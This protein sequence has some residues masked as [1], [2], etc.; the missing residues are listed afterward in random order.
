MPDAYRQSRLPF[1]LLKPAA[2][3]A[4]L[5]ALLLAAP[6][7][8]AE[9]APAP[10]PAP[11]IPPNVNGPRP[12]IA[13]PLIKKP[14]GISRT[15]RTPGG[16]PIRDIVR[17]NQPGVID[18]NEIGKRSFDPDKVEAT[19]AAEDE[20][21]TNLEDVI[22]WKSN[23]EQ[24][25]KCKKLPLNA[26]IRLDFNEISLGD[27]TKFI[28]CVTEQNFIITGGAN[29]N[30]T[31]SILSP[32]PVTA[33]EA[34]KAYLSALQANG[35]SITQNG[36]FLEI[37]PAGET[38]DETR[39]YGVGK[40]GPNT[41]QMV[42]RLI[43]LDHVPA[44]EVLPVLDKF[45]TKAGDITVYGPTNTMII[46]DT[47]RS[48][49]RLE[50]LLKEI[51]VP[52]GKERIWIRKV[53]HTA[54][55]DIVTLLSQII[56]SEG[57]SVPSKTTS[58]RT[59][60][61]KRKTAK[62][63]TTIAKRS[64]GVGDLSSVEVS[65]MIPDDRTNSIIFVASRTSYLKVDRII[66]KIDVPIPGE[67]AYHI[68]TLENG[69]A[70]EVSETLSRLVGGTASAASKRGAGGTSRGAAGA[71]SLFEGEVKITAYA[72]T[73]SLL[74]EASLKD[75]VALKKVIRQLDVRRKQVYVEA[76]IMEIAQN[77]NK[78]V[79][80]SGSGGTTFESDGETLPLLF[81]VGGL[82]LDVSG[83]LETLGQ[84]GGSIGLQGPLVDVSGGS[85][86]GGGT[87]S[88]P[89]FGFTLRALQTTTNVNVLSTPHIL[90][91]EN[92]EAEIQ[93]G[94]RQPYSQSSLGGGASSL[95]SLLGSGGGTGGLNLGSL[96]GLGA[97]GGL[98]GGVQYV[99]V[100]LTLKIKAQ[101]NASRFVR[102]EIDQSIDDI[103]GFG[104]NDA[105]ITSKRKV[106]N[107]VV[108]RDGQPVVIGGLIRD[109]ETETVEKVPF[110]G[111]IPLLG[112]LF[113][114]TS[115][116]MEKRNLLMIIIPHVIN[117]PSDLK[118]IYE[119]RRDE[120][121]E[122]ARVMAE[123]KK[124]FEGELDYR[125][126]SGIL[127]DMHLAIHAAREERELRERALFQDSQVDQVGDP[128]THDIEYD[129]QRR[130]QRKGKRNKHRGEQL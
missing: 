27:L 44:D 1:G 82:G 121:R 108:V 29:K 26:K 66:R 111:D 59:S 107:V 23:F 62:K 51:D 119:R 19:P 104:V 31:V 14:N 83:A 125:K 127:H 91:L 96:G 55:S 47:G 60:R 88:I 105:P 42:T 13:P 20:V 99:D 128:L 25:I 53:V 48:I 65:K 68:H 50:R 116:T 6:A 75:Y 112:L 118:R 38:K 130:F 58:K 43:Q 87:F 102:L 36:K 2:A 28:S 93:V 98:G 63:S 18:I 11:Q 79:G 61:S 103:D 41:D 54:A 5:A 49:R 74:I 114:R 97:L 15:P 10:D 115:T 124:E 69:D 72:P 32:K 129:P 106:T 77:K 126:K 17:G 92:E 45:K 37:A 30:A 56:S 67:G 85:D 39:I 34:Y 22:E 7:A 86:G 9:P 90:T 4:L 35:L 57:G 12:R 21:P 89:A 94:K 123:Q 71:A 40:R 80:L 81:G 70:E 52:T 84:G 76:I 24:G 100:D 117:D 78:S 120:Y 8:I 64:G 109:Q 46:T 73:N 101:V 113:R 16:D 110:L 122:F 33:Y 95:T 3:T